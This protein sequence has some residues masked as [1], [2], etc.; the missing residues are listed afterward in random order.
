VSLTTGTSSGDGNGDL[1]VNKLNFDEKMRLVF[2]DKDSLALK[3]LQDGVV[4]FS[5][6]RIAVKGASVVDSKI[7][8]NNQQ[9]LEVELGELKSLKENQVHIDELRSSGGT[10]GKG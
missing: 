7:L 8:G 9:L 6:K 1:M 10:L 2:D 3:S 5:D 4:D